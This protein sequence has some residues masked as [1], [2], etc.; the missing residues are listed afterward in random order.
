MLYPMF[1]L[2][3]L[4][5]LVG[6]RLLYLRVR[7]VQSGQVS[8]GIFRLNTGEGSPTLIQ[9]NAKN[10]SNLFE[11]PVLF[12]AAGTLSIILQRETHWMILL[13]WAFVLLR[14]LHTSIHLTYNNVLHRLGAFFT[15]NL[16]VLAMWGLLLLR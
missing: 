8:I 3:V 6:F 15:G 7:A 13:G 1:A 10:F 9:Q 16:I 12:F 11:V 14:I 2:V 4:I 5:N